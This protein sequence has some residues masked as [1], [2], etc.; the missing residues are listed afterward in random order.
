MKSLLLAGVATLAVATLAHAQPYMT[1]S[2]GI[3]APGAQPAWAVSPQGDARFASVTGAD[4]SQ[5]LYN[6]S[7]SASTAR[8]LAARFAE[9]VDLADQGTVGD[10]VTDDTAAANMAVAKVNAALAAGKGTA[11][12]LPPGTY[13]VGAV[14]PIVV[15]QGVT[16]GVFGSPGGTTVRER[17]G[18]T[19]PI[20]VQEQKVGSPGGYYQ[21]TIRDLTMQ[22]T[23]A[24]A[25][26]NGVEIDGTPASQGGAQLQPTV[27]NISC[28]NNGGASAFWYACAKV[29]NAEHVTMRR[30][31]D[32]AAGLGN[33]DPSQG[34][35]AWLYTTPDAAT[36][37]FSVDHHLSD[38]T[39]TGGFTAVRSD[40]HVEGLQIDHVTAVGPAYGVYSPVWALSGGKYGVNYLTLSGSHLNTKIAGIY[41]EACDSIKTSSDLMFADAPIPLASNAVLPKDFASFAAGNAYAWAGIWAPNSASTSSTGDEFFGFKRGGQSSTAIRL[42]AIDLGNGVPSLVGPTV[43]AGDMIQAMSS[44]PVQIDGAFQRVSIIGNTMKDT[45]VPLAQFAGAHA[46][47]TGNVQDDAVADIGAQNGQAIVA[48]PAALRSSLTFQDASGNSLSTWSWDTTNNNNRLRTTSSLATLGSFTAAGSMT[49]A[50]LI[51]QNGTLTGTQTFQDTVNNTSSTL[52]QHGSVLQ[53]S[54]PVVLGS[55]A[56]ASLPANCMAGAYAYA[57]DGR[58]SGEAS[59]SGS[60]VP[61]VCMPLIKGGANT[62]APTDRLTTTVTN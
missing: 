15:P 28:I 14:N 21:V 24:A 44:G 11:L 7:A 16:F 46:V 18:S 48:L 50:N 62:W 49:A 13:N 1:R 37:N 40:N 5:A 32:I 54:A 39:I 45:T 34:V 31:N 23:A 10:G 19:T 52:A 35:A 6:L 12:F 51:G 60:G 22:L 58:K 20:L 53:A 61:V 29:A 59:G 2:G 42:S 9:V 4:V 38:I 30:I 27:E 3:Q 57:T 43:I 33:G 17:L 41:C 26:G 36:A 55:L 56:T 8:S 47:M 25:G